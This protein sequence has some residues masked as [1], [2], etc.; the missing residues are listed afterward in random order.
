MKPCFSTTALR[1][2]PIDTATP[3]V[4]AMSLRHGQAFGKSGEAGY[5]GA[6]GSDASRGSAS[7]SLLEFAGSWTLPQD[8][9]KPPKKSQDQCG[10]MEHAGKQYWVKT[11]FSPRK[12]MFH[13]FHRSQPMEIQQLQDYRVTLMFPIKGE[14]SREE[15]D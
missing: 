10:C 8:V 2:S 1:A 3:R 14:R 15:A 9:V 6:A 12:R 13:P 4:K 5:D 11:H 7:M